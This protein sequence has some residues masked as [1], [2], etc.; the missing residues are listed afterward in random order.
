MVREKLQSKIVVLQGAL[1]KPAPD[2]SSRYAA[3]EAFAA[4]GFPTTAA[5]LYRHC[6]VPEHENAAK[7]YVRAFEELSRTGGRPHEGLTPHK[8]L[9]EEGGA[10]MSLIDDA[11]D[12]PACSFPRRWEKGKSLVFDELL[13]LVGLAEHCIM[14][15]ELLGVAG[16]IHAALRCYSRA[17]GIARHVQEP[18]LISC[19]TAIAIEIKVLRSFIQFVVS[20][21]CQPAQ[22][23]EV[24]EWL[25][26]LP[27]PPDR[28]R[29]FGF[30]AFIQLQELESASR[31]S[32]M[33]A[34]P[35]STWDPT[36]WAISRLLAS[37]PMRHEVADAMLESLYNVL[38]E[39]APTALAEVERW[40]D[41]NRCPP[42]DESLA[43]HIA[44]HIKSPFASYMFAWVRLEQARLIANE[45][46]AMVESNQPTPAHEKPTPVGTLR[47]I[48]RRPSLILCFAPTRG[49]YGLTEQGVF[50]RVLLD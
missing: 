26:Q 20:R 47:I 49:P 30:E 34:I 7:A 31:K 48:V 3:R 16:Q 6:E 21:V 5:D 27:P 18:T 44:Y 19:I 23:D 43:R 38:R 14:R 42:P 12:Y 2:I 39:P 35:L 50:M 10:L 37:E 24:S 36:R 45:V 33:E 46:I 32:L 8:V 40:W 41:S 13:Q 1:S 22:L 11:L 15:A 9:L 29:A 4:L 17:I 28:R 25:A